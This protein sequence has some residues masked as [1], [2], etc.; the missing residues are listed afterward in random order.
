LINF[1]YIKSTNIVLG[2]VLGAEFNGILQNPT[3]PWQHNINSHVLKNIH[4]FVIYSHQ[5][6]NNNFLGVVLGAEFKKMIQ[7]A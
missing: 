6:S 7:N 3:F 4:I 1:G 2:V 5:K